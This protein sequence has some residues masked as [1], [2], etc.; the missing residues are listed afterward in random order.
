MTA[1]DLV[2]FSG[3]RSGAGSDEACCT[4][5]NVASCLDVLVSPEYLD[6]DSL[7]IIGI[8]FTFTNDVP[9]HGYA[10]SSDAGD[11]A[12]LSYNDDN[13]NMFGSVHTHDGRAY[14]IEK[15][16]NGHVWKEFN[17]ASFPP[18]DD[19]LAPPTSSKLG[20][21]FDPK[22]AED[23]TTIVTYSVMFYYTPDFAALTPNIP[24]FVDQVRIKD[25][26]IQIT[27]EINLCLNP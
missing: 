22:S 23:N 24:D 20:I 13:G 10:Y 26:K 14:S 27:T 11:Q 7:T 1:G 6:D 8:D 16:E 4:D 3:G 12:V 21:Q 9:P 5:S 25:S 15:C 17:V 2:S 19:A 18:E